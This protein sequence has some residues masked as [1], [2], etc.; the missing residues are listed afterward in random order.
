MAGEHRDAGRAENPDRV[1]AMVL[2]KTAIFGGDKR[3]YQLRRHLL[4]RDGNTAFFA[5]LRNQ[6]A[7]RAIDLH[8]DLQAHILQG[9]DV[10]ELRL[11][12][13]IETKNRA[14]SQQYATDCKDKKILYELHRRFLI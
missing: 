7:I 11:Y 1:N 12:I 10:G 13:F 2:I 5:I 3:F 14:C 9:C 6:L 8:R 4:Q